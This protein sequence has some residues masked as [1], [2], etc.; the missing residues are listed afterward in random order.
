[1]TD[2]NFIHCFE[3]LIH[4]AQYPAI[5]THDTTIID[6]VKNYV[7]EH[8]IAK[9]SF[10]FQMLYGVRRE[11]QLQLVNEG[12]NVRIYVPFGTEWFPYFSRRLGERIGNVM[13][14]LKAMYLESGDEK[15]AI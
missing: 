8:K 13:F 12:Y 11:L 14:I 10:E 9:D 4:H 2:L 15:N 7:A 3:H 1:M 5:A 6:Y